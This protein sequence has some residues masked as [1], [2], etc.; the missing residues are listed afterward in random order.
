MATLCFNVT[1]NA[2]LDELRFQKQQLIEKLEASD[3]AYT[4][5]AESTALCGILALLD[6]I[7][8][9][10][11]LENTISETDVFGPQCPGCGE[12]NSILPEGN[13][14]R[15]YCHNGCSA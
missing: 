2:D 15:N 4:N 11:A 1:V 7:Q 5:T 12:F 3:C 8:D 14:W 13:G 10:A 6:H 9:T